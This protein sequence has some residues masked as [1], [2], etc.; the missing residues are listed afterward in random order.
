MRLGSVCEH[1]QQGRYRCVRTISS[2]ASRTRY[3]R[4][5]ACGCTSKE[6]VKIDSSTGRPLEGTFFS[7]AV[8]TDRNEGLPA[9]SEV[10]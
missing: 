2:G 1:C 9:S 7:V 8:S 3:L 5:P 6:V 4:C 10:R